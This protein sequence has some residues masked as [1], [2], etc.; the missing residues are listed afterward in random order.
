M[1]A[2]LKKQLLDATDETYVTS[3]KDRTT[4]SFAMVT[5]R[6][7]IEHLYTNYGRI[8]ANSLTDNENKMKKP[9][10]V[11]SPIETLFAQIDDNGRGGT[12]Y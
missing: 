2:A 3:L 10:D 11:M 9:W 7:L 5:M 1:D 12:V 8:N 6:T 4:T